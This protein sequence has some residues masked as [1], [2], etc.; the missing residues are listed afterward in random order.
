MLLGFI[1]PENYSSVLSR[2]NEEEKAIR[3]QKI[4]L[5]FYPDPKSI[6]VSVKTRQMK[7]T[8]TL[9]KWV[10]TRALAPQ[11]ITLILDFDY[12]QGLLWLKTIGTVKKEAR[13]T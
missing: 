6:A 10:G 3:D 2:L 11:M 4:A 5:V 9:K 12:Q 7:V 1:H 13:D 8:G